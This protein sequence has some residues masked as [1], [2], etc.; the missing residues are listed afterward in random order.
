MTGQKPNVKT[1]GHTS[2]AQPIVL[3]PA[4]IEVYDHL[5]W[6]YRQIHNQHTQLVLNVSHFNATATQKHLTVFYLN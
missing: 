5:A 1:V 2:E 3:E 4:L 6:F